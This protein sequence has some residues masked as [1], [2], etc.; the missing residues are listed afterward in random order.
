[1]KPN[2]LINGIAYSFVDIT[3][4]ISGLQAPLI[5]FSGIPIKSLSY[6]SSQ[7]KTMNYENSKYATSVSF[8]KMTYTGNVG[9]TL[10]AC[11]QLRDAV[12]ALGSPERS[13][14]AMPSLDASISYSVKGKKNETIIKNMMFIN[15]NMSGSEGNDTLAISAD[16]I[17]SY[18][19]FG[20]ALTP[21]AVVQGVYD[22][23]GSDNQGSTI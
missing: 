12:F 14:T 5:G 7:Q 11:E 9:L 4:T 22:F 6:N 15:E 21:I 16:W 13:L 18:I 19:S 8:G 2:T 3:F 23:I 10:D 17:A 20:A 1:M